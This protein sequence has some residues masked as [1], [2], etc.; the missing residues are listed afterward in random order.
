MDDTLSLDGFTRRLASADPTPGG[1]GAS[2]AVGALACSLGLM[3]ANLT[4]GKERYAGV[5]DELDGLIP[6]LEAARAEML[7][8]IDEDARAFAPLAQAYRI[9]KDD[10]ARAQAVEEASIQACTPPLRIMELAGEVIVM[11]DRLT[12]IGSRLAVSDGAAA[13][14]CAR[15]ALEAASLN[16]FI[17]AASLSDA[18]ESHRLKAAADALILRYS[19]K[20]QGV[21][22]RIVCEM[23]A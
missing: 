9:P 18:G 20:A 14:I 10:P 17:N 3:L 11:V 7:A 1:G 2:A 13:A 5:Q 22:E 19:P 16:V 21:F 8:L 4:S 6:R 23:E 15:A 12:V